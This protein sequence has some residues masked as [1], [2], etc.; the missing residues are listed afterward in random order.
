[1][2]PDRPP[3]RCL[4]DLRPGDHACCL[5]ESEE[6]R[7][8]VLDACVRY[9][10][11]RNEKVLWLLAAS[12]AEALTRSLRAGGLDVD[13]TVAAGRLVLG[14]GASTGSLTGTTAAGPI[15]DPASM[16]AWLRSE[17]ERAAAEGFAA[18]RFT[19]DVTGTMHGPRLARLLEYERALDELAGGAGVLVIC[20]YD[21]R[22]CEP[23]LLLEVL[24]EHPIDAIG[25]DVYENPWHT[26]P[27]VSAAGRVERWLE[28]LTSPSR[29][30]AASFRLAAIVESAEDAILSWTLDGTIVS[31]NRGA[32]RLYDYPA[33]EAIGQSISM[34]VP[35]DRVGEFQDI[36]DRLREGETVAPFDTIRLRR[37]ATPVHVSLTVSPIRDATGR[38]VGA[39]AIA[40]DISER[41]WADALLRSSQERFRSI[42]EH[43][44]DAIL[45]AGLDGRIIAANPAAC[46]M[47]GRTE[48]ELRRVGR[49]GT[50]DETDPRLQALLDDRRRTGRS[51]GELRLL[52]KDGSP[53]DGEVSGALFRDDAGNERMI[54]ILRDISERKR[55]EAQLLASREELRA[56]TAR[57]ASVREDERRA[58]ADEL[59]EDLAQRLVTL[60]WQLPRISPQIDER[61]GA[62]PELDSMMALL[63]E[64]IQALRRM[65]AELRPSLLFDLGLVPALEW[66]ARDFQTRSGVTCQFVSTASEVSLDAGQATALVRIA[67]H[68]LG[69]VARHAGATGVTVTLREDAE[70]VVLTIEDNGRGITSEEATS[71]SSLGIVE[72]RER[73]AAVGGTFTIVG[74]PGSGT[75]VTVAMPH[76]RTESEPIRG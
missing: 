3:S 34:L 14:P 26:P 23:S 1:M 64:T 22:E 42:F 36:V 65:S 33:A 58:I 46:A 73:A 74:Q 68:A 31:W 6:Q 32:E 21:R 43:S 48:S 60:K 10:L 67:Q 62:G 19:W 13:A 75:T 20:H 55:A 11:E 28:L 52:R 50:V 7:T 18:L 27:T 16:T 59:G 39:S 63:D 35:P 30:D 53:F 38:T 49:A 61:R 24:R 57:L 40:R 2:F 56:L 72:M 41:R 25:H 66:Q 17:T 12:S 4:V 37:N 9:G 54:L 45:L 71:P 44:L 70:Q 51:R 8:L 69:D 29:S 47:F 5:H 15:A 76:S